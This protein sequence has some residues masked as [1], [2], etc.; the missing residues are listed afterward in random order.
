MRNFQY[1]IKDEGVGHCA[2]GY[3]DGNYPAI[4]VRKENRVFYIK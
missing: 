3:I 1:V 4:P 2:L